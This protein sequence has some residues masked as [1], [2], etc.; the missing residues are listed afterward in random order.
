MAITEE[1]EALLNQLQEALAGIFPV[2]AEYRRH[3]DAARNFTVSWRL[4]EAED[5]KAKVA[6]DDFDQI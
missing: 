3:E 4:A 1:R 6:R 2:N 5:A